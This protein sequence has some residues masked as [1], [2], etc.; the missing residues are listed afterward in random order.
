MVYYV[1]KKGKVIHMTK[2]TKKEMFAQIRS[3]LTDP[4][5]IAFIDHELEL[6]EK[7]NVKKATTLSKKQ[8]EDIALI[9][10]I[11]NEMENG[12]RYTVTDMT[13]ELV[14]C[15]GLSPQKVTALV[16]KMRNNLMVAREV[17]KGKAYFVKM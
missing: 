1:C 13:S 3:H 9:E 5:E 17:T 7:K 15:N 2:I 4:A 10:N 12:K 11:F 6:L 8:K 14:T 16:T